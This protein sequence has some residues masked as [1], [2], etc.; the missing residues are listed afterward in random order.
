[1]NVDQLLA[2]VQDLS[3]FTTTEQLED[4]LWE[5]R[6]A[7]D[8][9]TGTKDESGKAEMLV[10]ATN[11]IQNKIVAIHFSKRR[12]AQRALKAAAT[13]PRETFSALGIGST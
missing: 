10:S 9:L 12:E 5:C 7:Y 8:R 1:M 13:F 3:L 11:R 2:I 6:T 4:R